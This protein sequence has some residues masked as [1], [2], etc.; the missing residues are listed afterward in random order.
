M[1]NE[2][3]TR[4]IAWNMED[5]LETPVSEELVKLIPFEKRTTYL[6]QGYLWKISKISNE[7]YKEITKKLLDEAKLN[8]KKYVPKNDVDALFLEQKSKIWKA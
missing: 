1:I 4:D 8:I 6:K 2:Y 5:L 3:N 7:E